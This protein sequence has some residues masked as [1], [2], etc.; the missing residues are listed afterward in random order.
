LQQVRL[1]LRQVVADR[2][3]PPIGPVGFLVTVGGK[4]RIE[5]GVEVEI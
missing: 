2:E 4:D 1:P 3:Q 5:I